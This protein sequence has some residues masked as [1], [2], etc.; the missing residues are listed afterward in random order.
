ML[1]SKATLSAGGTTANSWIVA[2]SRSSQPRVLY[3]K[4]FSST[5]SIQTDPDKTEQEQMFQLRS[6]LLQQ[7]SQFYGQRLEEA[8]E[9]IQWWAR[10]A[11]TAKHAETG[12]IILQ[13]AND[14]FHH[15]NELTNDM[16]WRKGMFPKATAVYN[17]LL[18]AWLNLGA[19]SPSP[20]AMLSRLR[21]IHDFPLD[22]QSYGFVM[23]AAIANMQRERLPFFCE[24]V[25]QH[26]ID[27]PSKGI[28]DSKWPTAQTFTR[29][30]TAWEICGRRDASERAYALFQIHKA[31]KFPANAIDADCLSALLRALLQRGV[32]TVPLKEQRFRLNL[33]N[34]VLL[35]AAEK[36]QLLTTCHYEILVESWL[37][38]FS[39]G[40]KAGHDM[41]DA[42]EAAQQLW[43]S[44]NQTH[45]STEYAVISRVLEHIL[46]ISLSSRPTRC[47]L[48]QSE[49]N[50]FLNV[51]T[52]PHLEK[53]SV[54]WSLPMR[55]RIICKML[56]A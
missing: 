42:M 56:N 40:R 25:F 36:K 26:M 16:S 1:R 47:D 33:A 17:S 44:L 35:H 19:C 32:F 46:L 38:H 55:D 7:T 29:C 31:T 5:C 12:H 22:N 41:T 9:C 13:Q 23:D 52:L 30:Y 50:C 48:R 53:F 43:R 6:V 34:D 18:S 10:R 51:Q 15:V 39:F 11:A 14:L 27:F 37:D 54:K 4:D 8:A 49:K 20:D 24:D 28:G 2:H 21:D 3:P 45:G